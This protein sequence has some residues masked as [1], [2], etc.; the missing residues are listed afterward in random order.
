MVD[1]KIAVTA[2]DCHERARQAFDDAI[3]A[4]TDDA[5]REYLQM[6]AEWLKLAAEISRSTAD[7]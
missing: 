2:E 5:K 3:D 4:A 6:A 7:R 1:Q